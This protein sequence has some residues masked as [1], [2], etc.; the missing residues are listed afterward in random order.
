MVTKKDRRNSGYYT[1][2]ALVSNKELIKYDLFVNPV[3]DEW[4][5]SR[6]GFREWYR[7]FK[8]IKRIHRKRFDSELVAKRILM[9]LKQKKLL[10][11][12]QARKISEKRDYK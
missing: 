6:D 9:N 4:I 10:K 12:R 1:P 8:L 2:L 3:Y 11:I 7:D 5:S